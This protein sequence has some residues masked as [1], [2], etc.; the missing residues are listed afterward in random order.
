MNEDNATQPKVTKNTEENMD[1]TSEEDDDNA[2]D[3]FLHKLTLT[4]SQWIQTILLGIILIPIRLVLILFFMLL[5]WI[6]SSIS[7]RI[8]SRGKFIKD[9]LSKVKNYILLILSSLQYNDNILQLKRSKLRHQDHREE[10]EGWPSDCLR[11]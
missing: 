10:E 6:I 11:L 2:V 1:H 3:P 5:M 7:L 8:V 4:T 9:I